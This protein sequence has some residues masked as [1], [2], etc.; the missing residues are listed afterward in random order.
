MS[1]CF[2]K[3]GFVALCTSHKVGDVMILLGINTLHAL[4]FKPLVRAAVS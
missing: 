3:R 4:F 1:P 2:D